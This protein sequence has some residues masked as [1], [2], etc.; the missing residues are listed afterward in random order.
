MMKF[1]Q[2][3]VEKNLNS[4]LEIDCNQIIIENLIHKELFDEFKI[5]M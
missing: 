5:Y 2:K 3:A 1:I 4:K